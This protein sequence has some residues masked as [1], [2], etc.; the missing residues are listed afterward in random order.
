MNGQLTSMPGH[1]ANHV[2]II[3]LSAHVLYC[4]DGQSA[5]TRA[6]KRKSERE[7]ERETGFK[8][9]LVFVCTAEILL[10]KFSVEFPEKHRLTALQTETFENNSHGHCVYNEPLEPPQNRQ[11]LANQ[12]VFVI[13]PVPSWG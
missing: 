13:L 6:R 8:A 1:V 7:R 5:T 4:R 3:R 2:L 9:A 10:G 12:P 11:R